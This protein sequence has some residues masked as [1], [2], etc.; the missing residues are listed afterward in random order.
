MSAS[1][2]GPSPASMPTE[3]DYELEVTARAFTMDYSPAAGWH[4][5]QLLPIEQLTS[6]PGAAGHHNDQ[7]VIEDLKACRRIDGTIALSGLGNT[8]GGFAHPRAGWRCPRCRT[9]CSYQQSTSLSKRR[10]ARSTK[11]RDQAFICVL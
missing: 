3:H 9:T 2:I 1:S 6:H 8:P 11:R 10:P 7:L 4:K 5:P